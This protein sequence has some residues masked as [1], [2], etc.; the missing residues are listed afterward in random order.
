MNLS[1]L[2]RFSAVGPRGKRRTVDGE[3]SVNVAVADDR[4]VATNEKGNV[5]VNCSAELWSTLLSR[6]YVLQSS[7]PWSNV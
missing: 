1:V 4:V 2:H 7:D 6:G 3:L 5:M